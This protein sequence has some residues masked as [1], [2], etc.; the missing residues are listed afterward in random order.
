MTDVAP[1]LSTRLRTLEARMRATAR[2]RA[3]A[4]HALQ[5]YPGPLGELLHRE[6]AAH[7]D[8]GQRFADGLLSRVVDQLLGA[9]A[10]DV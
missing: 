9:P 4:H 6:L 2:Y 3:A 1:D 7:A 5:A 10:D 8:L